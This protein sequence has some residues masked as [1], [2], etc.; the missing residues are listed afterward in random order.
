LLIKIENIQIRNFYM[1]EAVVELAESNK[2]RKKIDRKFKK[3]K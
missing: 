2:W 1:E 3:F